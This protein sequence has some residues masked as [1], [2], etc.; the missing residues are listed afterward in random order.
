[1]W[2]E[3]RREGC[4][5]NDSW[6]KQTSRKAGDFLDRKTG[7]RPFLKELMTTVAIV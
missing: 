2:E 7:V 6:I 3:S 1:M 4:Y 5:G